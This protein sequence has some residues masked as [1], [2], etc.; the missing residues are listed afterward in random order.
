[1]IVD[2][3]GVRLF[4]LSSSDAP[5][6]ADLHSFDTCCVVARSPS[7]LAYGG[8]RNCG[9]ELFEMTRLIVGVPE[10]SMPD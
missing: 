10:L 3:P 6:L 9:V 2:S 5:D 8:Q 1:M 4:C 7:L